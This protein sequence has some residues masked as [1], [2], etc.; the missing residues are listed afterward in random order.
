MAARA[1]GLQERLATLSCSKRQLAR[2]IGADP[3]TVSRVLRGI[4]TSA[5]VQR[6]IEAF[7]AQKETV[8]TATPSTATPMDRLLFLIEDRCAA[9]ALLM[10]VLEEQSVR[11]D[12]NCVE[13]RAL[14]LTARELRTLENAASIARREPEQ[15]A[16][17]AGQLEKLW[18]GPRPKSLL[19][20]APFR[21]GA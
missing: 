8:P 2:A 12:D 17:L 9:A 3:G 6:K 15:L 20:V 16:D 21:K 14:N 7:L 10:E 5:P 13:S 19:D 11:D 4:V 1:Q 18:C